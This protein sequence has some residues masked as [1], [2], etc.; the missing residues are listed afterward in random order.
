M[1]RP[2]IV[3]RALERIEQC[4]PPDGLTFRVLQAMADT[5]N[6]FRSARGALLYR[7]APREYV[8]L[9]RW[10]EV[11]AVLR[12]SGEIDFQGDPLPDSELKALSMSICDFR[13]KMPRV[14]RSCDPEAAGQ[15]RGQ[16]F[17]EA[18]RVPSWQRRTATGQRP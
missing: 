7:V 17:T 14:P 12:D 2:V 13:W 8:A 3:Y 5:G 15:Y 1:P 16:P 4:R 11:A 18:P 10:A 9:T 6:F